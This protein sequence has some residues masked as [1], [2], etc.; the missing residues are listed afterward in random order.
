MVQE[1]PHR[2]ARLKT[3]RADAVKRPPPVH[4]GDDMKKR[5]KR[6]PSYIRKIQYLWKLGV[7]PRNGVTQ[8]DVLHDDWCALLAQQGP[9]NCQPEV[10][11][12]Y[13]ADETRRN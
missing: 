4:R 1:L 6:V 12:R 13:V 10:K 9:C 7:V 5:A 2:E 11:L 8:L 3:R